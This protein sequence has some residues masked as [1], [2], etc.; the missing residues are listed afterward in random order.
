MVFQRYYHKPGSSDSLEDY[1]KQHERVVNYCHSDAE[2]VA[3]KACSNA[4]GVAGKAYSDEVKHIFLRDIC[5]PSYADKCYTKERYRVK[6]YSVKNLTRNVWGYTIYELY[7]ETSGNDSKLIHKVYHNYGNGPC[8]FYS[9]LGHLYLVLTEHYNGGL[10]FISLTQGIEYVYLPNQWCIS[11]LQISH[12]KLIMDG[13]FW[14]GPYSG[15]IYAFPDLTADFACGSKDDAS[16]VE[17]EAPLTLLYQSDDYF[18]V[19]EVKD[20]KVFYDYD[21][22]VFFQKDYD[23]LVNYGNQLREKY[24]DV[25]IVE[26]QDEEDQ[27][28]YP[29]DCDKPCDCA[30]PHEGPC[31][32]CYC[33]TI[34]TL[35]YSIDL[36][37]L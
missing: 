18:R 26:T 23:N 34:Y 25:T 8:Q 32:R 13:C 7:Q 4:E 33:N 29:C 37:T 19:A 14:G 30:A 31:E 24:S 15:K 17:F 1:K 6:I 21:I 11:N 10:S 3:G 27:G 12:G 20:G 2:G 9:H 35:R 22:D 5:Y 16:F 36:A 28:L